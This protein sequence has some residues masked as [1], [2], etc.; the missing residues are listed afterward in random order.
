[1]VLP[2]FRGGRGDQV[3]EEWFDII[4]GLI[5]IAITVFVFVG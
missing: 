2:G 1:M 4:V 5:V 3:R